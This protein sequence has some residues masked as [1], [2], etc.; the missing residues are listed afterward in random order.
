MNNLNGKIALVTGGN[1]G[2]GYATAKSLVQEG[3]QVIITGRREAA[4]KQAADELG[5]T[6]LVA[7]QG[8]VTDIEQ[9][10]RNVQEQFGKIDVLFINAGVG[11]FSSVA[12]AT[13]EGFDEI[14]D[15]NF[16]GAFF[17]LSRFIPLLNDGASVI[18]LSSNVSDMNMPNF[19]VYSASKAALNSIMKTAATELAP[20][21]IRVNAV[22]PGP[23]RTAIMHKTGLP[24][25]A[26]AEMKETLASKVPLGRM[27]DPEE[28]ASLVVYLAGDNSASIT[29]AEFTIDGGF[30]LVNR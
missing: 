10:A 21:H 14:M 19:S 2:I 20:Q 28:V 7:D 26:I 24:E 9:L 8:I 25:E 29:G 5:A 13:E 15:I 17:T 1:S 22:S 16:K 18:F 23:T 6:G 4:V 30:K 27:I 3:A 11:K 12:D